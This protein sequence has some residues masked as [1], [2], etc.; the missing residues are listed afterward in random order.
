MDN[1]VKIRNIVEELTIR[2]ENLIARS[3]ILEELKLKIIP[4]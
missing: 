3:K 2:D 1:L 4:F